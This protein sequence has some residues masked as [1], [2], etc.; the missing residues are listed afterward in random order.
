[1]ST[2]WK[3]EHCYSYGWDDAEWTENAGEPDEKPMRFNSKKEAEAEI[4]EHVKML[5]YAVKSGNMEG[6]HFVK[7]FRAVKV[8]P[9]KRTTCP[10]C[11][12]C[13]QEAFDCGCHRLLRR[14]S[15]CDGRGEILR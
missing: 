8:I 15:A 6:P 2:K 4:R 11:G 3:V 7:D 1:M 14:C 10:K 12:G 5:R 13:K 9:E